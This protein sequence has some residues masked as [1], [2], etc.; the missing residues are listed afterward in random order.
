[1]TP[2]SLAVMYG[3]FRGIVCLSPPRWR[4]KFNKNFDECLPDSHSP[5]NNYIS[6]ASNFIV[7]KEKSNKMQQCIKILLFPIYMKLNMFRATHRLSSGAENWT[8]SL[9]FF[10]RGGLLDVEVVDVVRHSTVPDNVHQLHVQQPS[11][12]KKTRGCQ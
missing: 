11:T 8:G 10:I 9:W 5:E 12:Y 3:H 7:H 4:R 6:T 1:M 2:F